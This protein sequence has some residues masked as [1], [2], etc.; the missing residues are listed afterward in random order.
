MK[1]A[2]NVVHAGVVVTLFAIGLFNATGVGAQS[3]VGVGGRDCPAFTFAL[4]SD[5]E[6]ALDAY[7]SWSQGF[8]SGFNWSNAHGRNVHVDPA[9]IINWLGQFCAA[10]PDSAV[11]A[12]VQELVHLNAR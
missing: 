6:A 8:I 1:V 11:F 10:N 12:A 5:S 4:E 7:V 2:R 3:A 9:A